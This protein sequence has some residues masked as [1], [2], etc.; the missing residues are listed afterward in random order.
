MLNSL[1][2]YYKKN[3][4]L[5]THFECIHKKECKGDCGNFTG[6]TSS[7]LGSG[8]EKGN[9]PRLLFLSLDSGSGEKD[10]LDRTPIKV[11]ETNESRNIEKLKKNTHWP[12]TH[13]IALHILKKYSN[14]LQKKDDVKKYFAHVNSA[15]CS[16]NKLNRKKANKVLFINCRNYLQKELKIFNPDIIITQGTEA[17][18]AIKQFTTNKVLRKYKDDKYSQIVLLNNKKIFWL[19]TYHPTSWG[20]K[21]NE[22][23]R[24]SK[25]WETYSKKIYKWYTKS[26]KYIYIKRLEFSSQLLNYSNSET[27]LFKNISPVDY[28]SSTITGAGKSGLSW[29]YSILLIKS[30][31]LLWFSLPNAQ[32]NKERHK[33]LLK[34]K[35]VIEN[36]FGNSLD[37]DYKEGRQ[38]HYIK[39]ISEDGGLNDEASWV[40]IQKDM[41]MRMIKLEKVLGKYLRDIE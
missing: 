34:N 27:D 22:Q 29:V 12:L 35:T 17:R 13:E 8:Y 20:G 26:D 19:H 9:L 36:E 23:R 10:P 11:R 1:E 14:E 18:E 7:F 25:N 3:G 33:K 24:N 38:N 39:S 31:V 2:N 16:M 32:K 6:P 5:S 4:I 15:K 41:V 28:Q 30:H 40:T 21:Y 37:W